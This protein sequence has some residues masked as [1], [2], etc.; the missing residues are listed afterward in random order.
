MPSQQRQESSKSPERHPPAQ[1][2]SRSDQQHQRPPQEPRRKRGDQRSSAWGAGLDRAWCT[3]A[4][5]LLPESFPVASVAG[6]ATIAPTVV[7]RREQMILL[8]NHS[9]SGEHTWPA[10][11]T[12][13]QGG[14]TPRET[15]DAEE[16][17]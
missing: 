9:H 14:D 17:S 4:L 10:V 3:S 16:M 15:D 6:A 12:L 11:S 1:G 8:C 2:R 13:I 7:D 5:T